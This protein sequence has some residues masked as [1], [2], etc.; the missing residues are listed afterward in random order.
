MSTI[1]FPY[2]VARDLNS[3]FTAEFDFEDFSAVFRE[4]ASL[5]L[6]LP[7]NDTFPASNISLRSSKRLSSTFWWM[8]SKAQEGNRSNI[9]FATQVFAM[10]L[11][12]MNAS[13]S[14]IDYVSR[15]NDIAGFRLQM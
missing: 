11:E 5:K 12:M 8:R 2:L 1:K 7:S 9:V 6:L 4:L 13:C 3:E 10:I 15:F 14:K